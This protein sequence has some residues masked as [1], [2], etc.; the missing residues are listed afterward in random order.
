MQKLD[1]SGSGREQLGVRFVPPTSQEQ[2]QRAQALAAR[3]NQLQNEGRND[4]KLDFRRL[5]DPSFDSE[6]VGPHCR[7]HISGSQLHEPH[8]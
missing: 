5:L 1:P 7:E 4:G 6:Q 2:H 8:P 3:A